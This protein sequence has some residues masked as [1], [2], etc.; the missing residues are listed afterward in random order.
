[1]YDKIQS[2]LDEMYSPDSM[3][4]EGHV[5]ECDGNCDECDI[6]NCIEYIYNG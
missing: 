4:E 6:N 2:E 5:F 3:F 1:M